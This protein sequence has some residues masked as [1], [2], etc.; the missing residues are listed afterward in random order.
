MNII[1]RFTRDRVSRFL[2]GGA[3]AAFLVLF[4]LALRGGSSALSS[5]E[6]AAQER[7]VDYTDTVLFGALTGDKLAAPVTGQAYR[8]LV[9]EVQGGI[10]TDPNVARVRVW[11]ADGTLVFSTDGQ[12]S[13]VVKTDDTAPID[14]AVNGVTTSAITSGTVAAKATLKGTDTQLYQTFAPLRV[15]DRTTVEAAAE[16]DQFHG[17]IAAAASQPWQTLRIAFGIGFLASLVLF[18]LSLRRA[19]T[20]IGAGVGFEVAGRTPERVEAD[21]QNILRMRN[22]LQRAKDEN[23]KLAARL[24]AET[25]A[26]HEPAPAG[27]AP[28]ADA[29]AAALRL[30][31]VQGSLSAAD[32]K[33]AELERSLASAEA[34]VAAVE[35]EALRA[36][37]DSVDPAQLSELERRVADAEQRAHD[38][39]LRLTDLATRRD[40]TPA[41]IAEPEPEPPPQR[42]PAPPPTPATPHVDRTGAAGEVPPLP[43][44]AEDLRSRLARTAAQKKRGSMPDEE[45]N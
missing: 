6:Q 15:P 3:T 44:D 27:G 12:K 30:A 25:H 43:A 1:D 33:N 35:A 28:H 41:H 45:H 17:E 7:A 21:E 37:G 39:E 29:G 24:E 9:I 34:R 23:R 2:W 18:V 40:A 20:L 42:E 10:M 11:A 19:T 36:L 14:A 22:E 16:I 13:V 31:E 32:A 38:A 4:L 8:D 26:V 5:E